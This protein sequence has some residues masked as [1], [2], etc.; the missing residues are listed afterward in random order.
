MSE[1]SVRHGLESCLERLECLERAISGDPQLQIEIIASRGHV[2]LRGDPDNAAIADAVRTV[3][4]QRLP[5]KPNTVSDGDPRLYWLGPDEWL[6]SAPRDGIPALVADLED[7]LQGLS[8]AVNDLSGGLVLLRLHG[9]I[10][11][12]VLAAGCPL[13]LRAEAFPP[14]SCA[15]SALAKAGVLLSPADEASFDI[16]VRSSFADYLVNWLAT[17]AGERGV[18]AAVR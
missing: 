13:D 14:G 11:R 1:R 18:S 10:A 5:V 15:Q 8:A 17:V 2:N 9:A 16:V 4:G 6:L 7:A 12:D 3:L